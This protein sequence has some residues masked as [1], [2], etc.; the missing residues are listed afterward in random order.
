MRRFAPRTLM[1]I[2]FI[3]F[4]TLGLADGALGPSWPTVRSEM[5]QSVSGL[6]TLTAFLTF[7]YIAGSLIA[8]RLTNRFG[9]GLSVA[10]ALA[11]Q[12]AALLSFANATTW[13]AMVVAWF[14]SGTGGGWQD[15]SLNAYFAKNH[16]PRAMNLLHGFFGVGATLAPLVMVALLPNWRW[17]FGLFAL[18]ATTLAGITL[19]TRP[20]WPS[21]PTTLNVPGRSADLPVLGAFFVY[22]GME[23]TAGQWAFTLL[24]EERGLSESRAGW[25]VGLF[26]GG[27]TLGR[28]VRGLFGSG[29]RISRSI[30]RS[31]LTIWAGA[32]LIWADLGGWGVT[33]LPILGLGM[34]AVFPG[35]VSLTP[36]RVG[37]DQTETA[38]GYQLAVA[39]LGAAFLP[40]LT[41]V[42]AERFSVEVLGPVLLSGSVL[43]AATWWTVR[44]SESMAAR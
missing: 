19:F 7:G 16:S 10:G 24:F 5:G 26:W 11:V 41:G 35:L 23:V 28:L 1:V 14:V 17:A 33:G 37:G 39:G 27:L 42:L 31:I 6:G 12:A 22:T 30:D 34:A 18:W 32:A 8:P 25:W 9:L 15:T 29:L 44:P 20:S 38:L 40:W 2:G 4:V 36:E 43:L 3:G 13:G 21:M